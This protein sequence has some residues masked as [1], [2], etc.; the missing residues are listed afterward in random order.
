MASP[1]AAMSG[2]PITIQNAATTGNGTVVAPPPSFR[3]HNFIITA[4]AGVTAGAI[5]IET[6][7][8]PNDANTW[9]PLGGG[10]IT[11][12]AG[13]DILAS[14]SGLLQ[15]VQARISTTISGG[16]SPSVT[17]KY[18]GAKTY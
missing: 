7:N 15:F 1:V 2:V 12:I 3:N 16:G 4:A 14:F 9:A 8:D 11:V 5:Q 13:V 10:P 6:S 17:V 18:N